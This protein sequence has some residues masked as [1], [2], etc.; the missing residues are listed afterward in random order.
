MDCPR[1]GGPTTDYTL[2]GRS[3]SVCEDCGYVGVDVDHGSEVPRRESWTDAIRRFRTGVGDDPRDDD[4][5]AVSDD[6]SDDGRGNEKT[7]GEHGDEKTDGEH[8]DEK[9]DG[10]RDG[11]CDGDDTTAAEQGE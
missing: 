11:E 4:A 6:E 2:G 8:G 1:C 9:T 5:T 3:A 10:E 7:D